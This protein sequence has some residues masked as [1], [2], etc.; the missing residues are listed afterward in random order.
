MTHIRRTRDSW[1]AGFRLCLPLLVPLLLLAGGCAAL[2]PGP[3]GT[4]Q[5][6]MPLERLP[7]F[8]DDRL[9]GLRGAIAQQ[10][11]LKNPPADWS[12]LCPAFATAGDDLAGWLARRFEAVEIVD[13]ANP[14]GL[15]TGYF[16]PTI[17]GSRQR[18]H[19]SQVPILPAPPDLLTIDLAEVEPKLK[20][21][22]LRGRVEG[23]RV[24]PYYSRA[25]LAGAAPAAPL[26]WA[27]DPVELF[28]LEIQG[29]GRLRLRDGAEL[30]IGYADQNGHPYRAIGRTLIEA[31]ELRREDVTAQSIK[32]WLRAHPEQAAQVM[33]TNASQV[34]FRPL[35][36][37]PA[38]E[39]GPPGSLGVAL[40]PLRSIAVDRERI[41]LGTLVWL[42][43]TDP[44]SGAP[45]RRMTIAQDTGGAIRGRKRAD[46]FWGS[47]ERAEQASGAMKAPGRFWML[48]S[49]SR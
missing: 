21:L 31:G 45:L 27:D 43:T 12:L 16:E 29:S 14:D 39:L 25:E 8:A 35:P 22:R 6:P 5:R 37:P 42:D 36:A 44:V 38:P 48:V 34:F 15:V 11:A 26:G 4:P 1:T 7:G 18:E 40:T 46:L 10:C 41:A 24:V 19:A 3:D 20:G 17:S 47:G 30:R 32:R 33:N 49:R 13:E 28:F 2:R 23:R 9:D